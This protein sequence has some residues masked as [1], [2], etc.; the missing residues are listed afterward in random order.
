[1]PGGPADKLYDQ[2][3]PRER[4]TLALEA[5]ARGDDGEAGRVVG[6]CP[7]RGFTGPNRGDGDGD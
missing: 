7:R 1:M 5:V 6:S 2:L 4:L 3:K